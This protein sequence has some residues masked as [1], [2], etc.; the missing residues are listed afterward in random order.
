MIT[1]QIADDHK[2]IVD[3]FTKLI[4]ESGLA[5]V[6][7]VYYDLNSC[8]LGLAKMVPDILLLDIVIP[9]GD[10]IDFCAEIKKSYPGLSVIMLTVY[11]ESSIV[12]RALHNG[13]S[14]YI[15]K[16]TDASE[17]LAGIESVSRGECFLCKETSIL[18]KK[19]NEDVIWLLDREKELLNYIAAGY[20][21]KEIADLMCRNIETIRTHRKNLLIKL[22]A[23]NMAELIKKGYEMGL[24]R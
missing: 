6:D 10:G 3:G 18:L 5:I 23:R 16:N 17:I 15:L 12:K 8:R 14:G 13:A 22:K 20:P 2:M 7:N 1:I 19:K 21:T 4:N 11:K 24:I 9:G